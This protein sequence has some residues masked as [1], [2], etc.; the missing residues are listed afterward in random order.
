MS[1]VCN[2]SLLASSLSNESTAVLFVTNQL[3]QMLYF[4]NKYLP[5]AFLL[6]LAI[7]GIRACRLYSEFF[8]VCL[9]RN[10]FLRCVYAVLNF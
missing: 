5:V 6:P 7:V 8:T 2:I 9:G 10:M 3:M 1:N 4:V